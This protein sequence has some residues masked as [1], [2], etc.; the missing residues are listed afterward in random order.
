[1]GGCALYTG[2]SKFSSERLSKFIKVFLSMKFVL[3]LSICFFSLSLHSQQIYT[4]DT[5]SCDIGKNI[6]AS[7]VDYPS[8]SYRNFESGTVALNVSTNQNGCPTSISIN[9]SS[10]FA[11]LDGAVIDAIKNL[12][13]KKFNE[14][15]QFKYTFNIEGSPHDCVLEKRKEILKEDK[16]NFKDSHSKAIQACTSR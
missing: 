16:L 11:R 9:E 12:K 8:A 3:G 10:G 15:F 13:F 14:H 6:T 1:V 4:V 5:A 7:R 2:L